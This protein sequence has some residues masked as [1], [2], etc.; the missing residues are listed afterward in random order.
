MCK[1]MERV[2]W[3]RFVYDVKPV[4]T[5]DLQQASEENADEIPFETMPCSRSLLQKFNQFK[6]RAKG[7][8]NF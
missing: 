1:A 5:N 2:P 3:K 6:E 7:A 8:E 4:K